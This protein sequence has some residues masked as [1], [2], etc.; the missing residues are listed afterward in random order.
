MNN[1][2]FYAVAVMAC[3]VMLTQ[4]ANAAKG[5]KYSYGEFGYTGVDAVTGDGDGFRVAF[6]FGATDY[7]NIIGEY[8]RLFGT[9]D[10]DNLG[11][12][13]F[14]TNEDIDRDEFKIGGGVHY[15]LTDSMDLTFTAVYVDQQYTGD[16]V[17]PISAPFKTNVNTSEEGYEAEFGAR[18][19]LFNKFEMTPHVIHKE[20]GENSNTGAGLGIVYKFYKKFSVRVKGTFYDDDSESQMFAGV[21]LKL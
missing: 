11:G 15:P 3:L 12:Q 14:S 8:N 13:K 6:S 19:K 9:D 21:R 1:K 2:R 5:F 18:I 4:S 10:V 17:L 7:V 16:W 20:V